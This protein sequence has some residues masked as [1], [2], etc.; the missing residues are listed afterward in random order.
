MFLIGW[1]SVI[2]ALLVGLTATGGFLLLSHPAPKPVPVPKI[3]TPLV[4][5]VVAVAP[6]VMTRVTSRPGNKM[7]KVFVLMYHR[8]GPDEKYMVRSNENFRK[9]LYA[10]YKMGW[11]PV[12]M[13]DYASNR[14]KLAPGATPVVFTFDDSHPSQ[15][16]MRDDGS[17][18]PHC[19]VGIWKKFAESHPD[20]PVKATFYINANGPWGSKKFA[21][22]KLAL[23][24]QWG[25]ELAAHTLTHPNL[26]KLNDDQVKHE[27]A[28]IYEY[29]ES[30]GFK[31][32]SFALPYG[33]FPLNHSL[34][35]GL[36]WNNKTY[37]YESNVLA[38]DAPNYS[39][40]DPKFNAYRIYRIQAFPGVTGIDWWIG[41]VR[42]GSTKVYVQP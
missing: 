17:I 8:T 24:K 20:F 4:P 6:A 40:Q 34:V 39:P 18:D 30:R 22:K 2:A 25:S 16:S 26:A 19:F 32:K 7:G 37:I 33:I 1:K 13:A 35:H 12:T 15:F 14:M 21:G 10:M 31:P 3:V 41:K 23:L 27:I 38:G 5:V 11:R 42:S 29:I 9:D 28:G 36:H